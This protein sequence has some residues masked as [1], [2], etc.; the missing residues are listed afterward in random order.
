MMLKVTFFFDYE[1]RNDMLDIVK[2]FIYDFFNYLYIVCFFR[3][4]LCSVEKENV[5]FLG[6]LFRF[7]LVFGYI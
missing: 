2:R 4:F 6:S 5:F 7:C 3:D 1:I